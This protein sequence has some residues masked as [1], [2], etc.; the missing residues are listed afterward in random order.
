MSTVV[1]TTAPGRMQTPSAGS[2]SRHHGVLEFRLGWEDESGDG[3]IVHYL[4]L[5]ST[6]SRPQDTDDPAKQAKQDNGE[7]HCAPLAT[8][9]AV[10]LAK[11]LGGLENMTS[12]YGRER[13]SQQ[14]GDFKDSRSPRHL[15]LNRL[16]LW[17]WQRRRRRN[18]SSDRISCDRLSTTTGL[19]K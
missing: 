12:A 9:K 17:S 5:A 10:V 1:C 8:A 2:V 14:L 6:C 7:H 16:I 15:C 13:G 18:Q 19:S 3:G 4:P 11:G